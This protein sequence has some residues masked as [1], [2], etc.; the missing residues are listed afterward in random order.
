M[1]GPQKKRAT[2][3]IDPELPERFHHS[4]QL[5]AGG[6]VV[7]FSSGMSLAEILDHPFLSALQLR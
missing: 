7:Q 6:A 5:I 2:K 1:V 3:E 4:Q